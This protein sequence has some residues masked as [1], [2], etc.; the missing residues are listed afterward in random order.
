MHTQSQFHVHI[1]IYSTYTPHIH[2][3]HVTWILQGTSTS[4]VCSSVSY[5]QENLA[6]Q[7]PT[8]PL[9]PYPP[10]LPLS[11]ERDNLKGVLYSGPD[12]PSQARARLR[13][14]LLPPAG[15]PYDPNSAPHRP[16]TSPS[17][18]PNHAMYL[19]KPNVRKPRNV[20]NPANIP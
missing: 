2:R 13:P 4:P 14:E 8:H 15:I 7:P 16:C 3:L 11:A 9:A 5:T 1:H 17:P 20:N 10:T 19:P 18:N 6:Q 12:A